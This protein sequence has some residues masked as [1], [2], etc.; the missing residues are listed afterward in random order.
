MITIK[1]DTELLKKYF[2]DHY[3]F[4]NN[5]GLFFK[6]REYDLEFDLRQKRYKPIYEK[7]VKLCETFNI[8]VHVDIFFNLYFISCT[9]K[10][11]Q[12]YATPDIPENRELKSS[13]AYKKELFPL[14]LYILKDEWEKK[15]KINSVQIKGEVEKSYYHGDIQS[16]NFIEKTYQETKTLKI[17]NNILLEEFRYFILNSVSEL[18]YNKKWNELSWDGE[19]N[20]GSII[21]QSITEWMDKNDKSEYGAKNKTYFIGQFINSIKNFIQYEM[22]NGF[23]ESQR[24][25]NHFIGR[26]LIDAYGLI[27]NPDNK[28]DDTFFIKTVENHLPKN[29]Q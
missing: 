9:V 22:G 15:F 24:Q 21:I 14:F 20:E 7:V 13:I 6:K 3:D 5:L 23:F 2:S 19:E 16:G 29:S 10:A 17:T 4:E 1:A 18:F 26:L 12:K 25:Q 8:N 27:P 11:R 28:K